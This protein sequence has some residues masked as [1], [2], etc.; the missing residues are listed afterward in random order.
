LVNLTKN[1]LKD[2]NAEKSL[3]KKL[4]LVDPKKDIIRSLDESSF[5]NK[6]KPGKLLYKKGCRNEMV[7]NGK[8]DLL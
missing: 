8:Y 6:C 7:R 2:Q 3:K 5:D 4:E 1:S